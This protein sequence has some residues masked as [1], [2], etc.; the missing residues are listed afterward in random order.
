MDT[1]EDRAQQMFAA[2]IDRIATDP[3]FRSDLLADPEG[4]IVRSG[5]LDDHDA[6]LGAPGEEAEVVG[7]A[8]EDILE[9]PGVRI[10]GA[11]VG[12]P[13]RFRPPQVSP[14]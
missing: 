9:F 11:M 6:E 14:R 3:A 1:V 4:A 5:I 7:F 10:V 8:K 12:R 2:V 13:V